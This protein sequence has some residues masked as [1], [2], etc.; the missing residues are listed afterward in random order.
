MTKST[1]DNCRRDGLSSPA[2]ETVE[3]PL[4]HPPVSWTRATRLGI[5]RLVKPVARDSRP[6]SP[7]AYSVGS[8]PGEDPVHDPGG[9]SERLHR[10]QHGVKKGSVLAR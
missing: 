3:P 9:G 1:V 6:R 2:I 5:R 7:R 8:G 4:L 10:P